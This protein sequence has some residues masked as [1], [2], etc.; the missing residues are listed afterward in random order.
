MS[1]A[2]YQLLLESIKRHEGL[3]LHPIADAKGSLQIGHGRN[4]TFTGI[5]RTE[6]E[7]L[8]END[9]ADRLATLPVAWPPFATCD[10]AVQRCLIEM[11]YQL[12]VPGLLLF[13]SLLHALAVGNTPA[14]V[15][16]LRSSA[17]AHQTPARAKDYEELLTT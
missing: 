14:A 2:D 9:V 12:G 10:P 15:L 17:L 16:A 6:A 5:S 11:S 4:L 1:P 3:S 13:K 8:L 7:Y